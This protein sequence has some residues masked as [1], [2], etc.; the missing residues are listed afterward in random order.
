L[1]VPAGRFLTGSIELK[2]NVQ[3]YLEREAVLLGS[4]NWDDYRTLAGHQSLILAEKQTHISISG[5]GTVDGQGRQLGLSIDS[6]YYIGKLDTVDYEIGATHPKENVRPTII[7]LVDC[8]NVR[9]ENVTLKNSSG[10]LEW[11][12]SCEDLVLE[13]LT[14]H[15]EAYHN[16]DGINIVDCRKVRITDCD[17]N[18]VDD[19]ICLKGT[20]NEHVWIENCRIRSSA[21][22]IKF[23]SECGARDVSIR[24]VYIYD[25]YRAALALESVD[26]NRM[27]DISVDGL[28]AVN[29]WGILFL[30][31]GDRSRNSKGEVGTLR[32]VTIR[33]VK[34][35]VAY[36]RPDIYYETRFPGRAFPD[37]HNILPVSIT[38]IPGHDVE[39][40]LLENIDI[41]H[42]GRGDEGTAHI[43]LWRLDDVREN[44]HGYPEYDLFG[45][46]P[47]WGFYVRHARGVTFK[48]V[49]V[50][51]EKRDSRPAYVFD[52]VKGVLMDN[53]RIDEDDQG[54]QIILRTNVTGADLKVNK[55]WV[56][57]VK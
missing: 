33:N 56:K 27:E 36:A 16:N 41:T 40:V 21:S 54:P 24:N 32:N 18:V 30:R 50:R 28:Y 13:N 51:A 8:K 49:T 55:E 15:S 38:G 45:E 39:N 53:I 46:L 37:H 10:W 52:D 57:T 2:S 31:L 14:V 5:E 4:V 43:P 48:K 47:A 11:Y 25:T 17:I 6:L 44:E 35:Y 34:A 23:G 22:A 29:T 12:V 42:P 20:L 1:I 7:W 26:G 19:G 3:L 9:V